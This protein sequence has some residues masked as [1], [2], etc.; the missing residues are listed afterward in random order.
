M[1]LVKHFR[2]LLHLRTVVEQGSINKAALLAG[3]SQPALTRSIRRLEEALGV[4]LLD[5]TTR[6]IAPTP[7]GEM[8]INHARLIDSELQRAADALQIMKGG[9]GQF[10][11][12]A[13][14]GALNTLFPAAIIGLQ[15]ER[16][17]LRV[18]VVEGMPSALMGMVRVG[19][20]DLAVIARIDDS[21]EP[22]LSGDIVSVD[23]IDIFARRSHPLAKRDDNRLSDLARRQSW[24]MPGASGAIYQ[25]VQ[26]RLEEIGVGM[27]PAFCETSSITMLR[28][29]LL[30]SDQIAV[31]TSQAV[32]QELRSGTIVRLAGD[33]KWLR[34]QTI[35][36]RRNNVAAT[37]I[38]TAFTRL[39]R[40]AAANL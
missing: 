20:L 15:K 5:R 3:L 29:L 6:G 23:K 12:G 33:W 17:K 1:R 11:C 26:R 13:T 2:E 31:T 35:A 40:R 36:Y 4:R 25:S 19:E 37:P 24:I 18:R 32:A 38:A 8:L 10:A 7:Y 39:L 16:P 27:P 14:I 21:P 22:E 28:A 30:N 34:T 9:S